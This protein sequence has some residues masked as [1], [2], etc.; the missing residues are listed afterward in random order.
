V[1][2]V[3]QLRFLPPLMNALATAGP[4]VQL[5]ALPLDMRQ[6]QSQLETGVADIAL[7]AFPRATQGL[8]RQRLY[9]EGYLSVARADH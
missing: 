7:G 1:S 9:S 6:F 2:D 5:I 3:G 4:H 8:R